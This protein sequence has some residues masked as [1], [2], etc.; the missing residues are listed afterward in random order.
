MD[1]VYAMFTSLD[2]HSSGFWTMCARCY[3]V[4]VRQSAMLGIL[5]CTLDIF[6]YI[7]SDETSVSSDG[8]RFTN[9]QKEKKKIRQVWLCRYVLRGGNNALCITREKWQRHSVSALCVSHP[10]FRRNRKSRNGRYTFDRV[11]HEATRNKGTKRKKFRLTRLRFACANENVY[12]MFTSWRKFRRPVIGRV[13]FP[14][15]LR[16]LSALSMPSSWK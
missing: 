13:N 4:C 14:V 5:L 12:A 16:L 8:K 2:I 3:A 15:F 7:F 11:W 1:D 10:C 9:S 6:F